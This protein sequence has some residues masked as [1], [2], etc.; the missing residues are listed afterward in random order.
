MTSLWLTGSTGYVGS[1]LVPALERAGHRLLLPERYEVTHASFQ[2]YGPPKAIIH[3]AADTLGDWHANVFGTANVL[4]WC[5][6]GSRFIFASTLNASNPRDAYERE[7]AAAHSI[8]RTRTDVQSVILCLGLVYG[9]GRASKRGALN[10]VIREAVA[11]EN[12]EIQGGAY[13]LRDFVFIDDVV[14]AFV[15]ALSAPPGVYEVGCTHATMRQALLEV[16][17][18][19]ERAAHEDYSEHG[20][21]SYPVA[22]PSRYV[23]GWMPQVTLVDGIAR[24]LQWAKY[25]KVMAA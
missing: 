10:R 21:V 14:R 3:L 16:A 18:Q 11:G 4:N 1:A 12:V 17:K 7:K 8:V 13:G 2:A 6:S 9:P 23:P 20:A 24:T 15:L 22:H 25:G 19:A 5:P